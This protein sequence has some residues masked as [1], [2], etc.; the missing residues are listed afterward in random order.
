MTETRR[1]STPPSPVSKSALAR[2]SGL[3]A[4]LAVAGVF[5]A[6]C[7]SDT[8]DSADASVDAVTSAAGSAVDQAT[9][10]AAGAA[11]DASAAVSGGNYKNGQYSATGSY[12]SPGGQQSIGVSVTLNNDVITALTLD[13][14]QTKGTSAQFQEKFAS[15]IDELVVGKDIDDLDVS[16]VAGSSLTS[17]GFNSAIDQIKEEAKG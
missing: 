1:A 3:A 17:G 9:S 7:G 11:S 6:A 12:M 2:T 5:A 15:G 16:K 10:A 4:T 14:S 13:R 8:S